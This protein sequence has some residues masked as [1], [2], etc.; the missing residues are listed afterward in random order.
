VDYGTEVNAVDLQGIS[1]LLYAVRDNEKPEIASMLFSSYSNVNEYWMLNDVIYQLNI[2]ELDPIYDFENIIR[3]NLQLDVFS[4]RTQIFQ[5]INLE[6]L[7]PLQFQVTLMN[8]IARYLDNTQIPSQLIT[9][10]EESGDSGI[11]YIK[12]SHR[13]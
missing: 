2:T 13:H 12:D 1:P 6:M 5:N 11:E 3:N 8:P 4:I 9:Y 7:T 10:Y